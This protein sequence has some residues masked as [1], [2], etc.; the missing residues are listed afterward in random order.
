MCVLSCSAVS[1]SLWP[2]DCSLPRSSVYGIS[3]QE[4]WSGLPLPPTGD[5][6]D[7]G[8]ELHLPCLL[9]C[10]WVLYYWATRE[11]CICVYTCIIQ[12]TKCS[13]SRSDGDI[14]II[15]MSNNYEKTPNKF[16]SGRS[17]F[18]SVK[19]YELRFIVKSPPKVIKHFL[20][21]GD[22]E[23]QGNLVCCSPWGHKESDTAEW[24]NNIMT[25]SNVVFC[26]CADTCILHRCSLLH[27]SPSALQLP[28]LHPA[29]CSKGL[30][31]DHW[32]PNLLLSLS[33]LV[34]LSQREMSFFLTL[35]LNQ[36]FFPLSDSVLF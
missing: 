6:L 15:K 35:I 9:H 33:F 11:A 31:S 10:R 19:F 34:G 36:F 13:F 27:F 25:E 20:H 23:G 26:Q 18:Y 12:G 5:F 4:C 7:P 3:Q 28:R 17:E 8:I 14:S 32:L 21:Q 2:Q 22:S 29:L 30:T 16:K 24:L 1:D